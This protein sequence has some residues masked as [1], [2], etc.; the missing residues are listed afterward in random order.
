MQRGGVPG[1][2]A[3]A[4]VYRWACGHDVVNNAVLRWGVLG[5]RGGEEG[6]FL[7]DCGEVVSGSRL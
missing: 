6:K 4:A 1:I 7:Q 3:R 5:E 2:G